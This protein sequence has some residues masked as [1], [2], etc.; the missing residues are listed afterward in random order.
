MKSILGNDS[1]PLHD[2]V[3]MDCC[4][5]AAELRGAGGLAFR[6]QQ[7]CTADLVNVHF[8]VVLQFF[9]LFI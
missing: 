5:C 1:L 9:N 3:V 2:T 4:G 7:D 8:I 6:Q